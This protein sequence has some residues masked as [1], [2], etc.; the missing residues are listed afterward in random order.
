MLFTV[1]IDTTEEWDWSAGWPTGRPCVTNVMALPR[2]QDLCTRYNVRPTYFVDLAVLNDDRASRTI[3][4]FA[5]NA[6]I[7][8]GMRIHP[9]NTPPIMDARATTARETFLHNLRDDLIVAK[10]NKVYRRFKELGLRPT[11]FRGG[12]YSSGGEVTKFLRRNRFLADASVLPLTTWPDDGAPDYRCR[13]PLPQRLPPL[14][15][16][17]PPLWEI[18]LT[19]TFNRQ[20]LDFWRRCYEFVE[21]S[22]LN[23]LHLIGLAERLGLIRRIWLNFESPLGEHML[24]F[25]PLANRFGWPHLCFTVHSSSLMAGK[26]PYTRTDEDE[27]RIY[28]LIER[29]FAYL[30]RNGDF[31]PVTTTE[32]ARRLESEYITDTRSISSDWANLAG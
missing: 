2:F 5:K 3:L 20:P 22:G 18:P 19:L 21:K 27:N 28:R 14:E 32:L 10:L 29:V 26:G 15:Q 4:D 31:V 7:E 13:G 8:I 9:W 23:K 11:S 16:D 24:D 17:D 25:L 12:R 1:T 30:T 6:T